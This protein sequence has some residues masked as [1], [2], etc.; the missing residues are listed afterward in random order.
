MPKRAKTLYKFKCLEVMCNTIHRK[1]KWLDHCNKKHSYKLKNNLKINYKVVEMK[2][3]NGPW[4]K[5]IP[6]PS[7]SQSTSLDDIPHT[8]MSRPTQDQDEDVFEST[9]GSFQDRSTSEIETDAITLPLLEVTDSGLETQRSDQE[10]EEQEE[11]V[12]FGTS[13]V[14]EPD[15]DILPNEDHSDPAS[16]A[17]LKLSPE[18]INVALNLENQDLSSIE[19]PSTSGRKFNPLWKN[20]ILPNNSVKPRKWLVYS[21]K[22]DAVFCLPCTLFALPTER[23]VWGTAGYRGWTEHRGE[24][25]FVLHETSKN[26]ISAEVARIQ[27]ISKK[28]GQ[29][30]GLKSL[31]TE[32]NPKAFYSPTID[33]STVP[34]VI[35]ETQE[36]L[37]SM[38]Q[39]SAWEK[40]ESGITSFAEEHNIP[41][42]TRQR[43]RKRKR[44]MDELAIDGCIEDPIKKVKVDIY[45]HVLDSLYTQLTDRFPESSLAMVTQMGY[46][47][48]DGI[49]KMVDDKKKGLKFNPSS[50]ENLSEYYNLDKELIVDELDIFIDVYKAT[51]LDIDISDVMSEKKNSERTSTAN[52]EDSLSSDHDGDEEQENVT[53]TDKFKKKKNVDDWMKRG[54][55]RPY[56]SS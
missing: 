27:W 43:I 26:H 13:D 8:S 51:Y 52:P 6:G 40:I 15:L 31:V 55:I 46:F 54:F 11:P 39:D 1:D 24:R 50:I 33:Y 5:Y 47:S 35:K 32:E 49:L 16:Y 34:K 17:N 37:A 28:R 19:F 7:S 25:D 38:R 4:Q 41:L 29:F 44:F 21:K 23:S 56:R 2:V 3:N 20:C 36:K 30:K 45:F 12:N 48:H 18:D 10:L 9:S 42:P 22:K 53:V 14:D